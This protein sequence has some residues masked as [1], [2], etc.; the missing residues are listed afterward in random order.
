VHTL[1]TLI[2][3]SGVNSFI[4][5]YHSVRK[6]TIVVWIVYSLL[7]GFIGFVLGFYSTYSRELTHLRRVAGS[8]YD[9]EVAR[10]RQQP[11]RYY[12][13]WAM[14]VL[15]YVGLTDIMGFPGFPFAPSFIPGYTIRMSEF[16]TR[17]A[18]VDQRAIEVGLL[19][20]IF[21][22]MF[23]L[24]LAY[25]YFLAGIDVRFRSRSR[26]MSRK[27]LRRLSTEER[28]QY[29]RYLTETALRVQSEMVEASG[30]PLWKAISM[31]W[32][33]A[34][35]H[36]QLDLMKHYADTQYTRLKGDL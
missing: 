13:K 26:A 5:G 36:R 2:F 19:V 11:L 33:M 17:L 23:L 21:I 16:N 1:T 24:A 6:G 29:V 8:W 14:G 32:Q 4:M 20:I 25:P 30:I 12:G 35:A 10:G 18:S 27:A 9:A 3:Q 34:A 22:V 7:V 15:F 31:R 28:L